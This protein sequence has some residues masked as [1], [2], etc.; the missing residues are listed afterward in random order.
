MPEARL[1]DSGSGL[2]ALSRR[3]RG[4]TPARLG[5]LPRFRVDRARLRGRG[6]GPC[7]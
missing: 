2:C 1:E 6:Q 3:E 7:V 4:E 5:L